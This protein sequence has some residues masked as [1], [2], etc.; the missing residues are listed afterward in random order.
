MNLYCVNLYEVFHLPDSP[1]HRHQTQVPVIHKQTDRFK[2]GTGTPNPS[3]IFCRGLKQRLEANSLLLK[4]GDTRMPCSG[5]CDHH[6][7]TLGYYNIQ[8]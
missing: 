6:S 2:A 8:V 3:Y 4:T 7:G 1:K 5:D